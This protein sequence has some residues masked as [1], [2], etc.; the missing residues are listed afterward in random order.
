[1]LALSV[2]QLPKPADQ[3]SWLVQFDSP[4]QLGNSDIE[5]VTVGNSS[6]YD[7]SDGNYSIPNPPKMSGI[8]AYCS[9]N[10]R[11]GQMR[12]SA[13]MMSDCSA[14]RSDNYLVPS[15]CSMAENLCKQ[16]GLVP[17]GR[18]YVWA[19]LDKDTAAAAAADN[20]AAAAARSAH[21]ESPADNQCCSF[22]ELSKHPFLSLRLHPLAG[23]AVSI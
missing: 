2:S 16:F 19:C 7:P 8:A 10:V 23:A 9:E 15:N 11:S 3:W 17:T 14:D 21:R 1:M 13:G 4:N 12:S 22:R 18:D 20:S 6:K 5:R